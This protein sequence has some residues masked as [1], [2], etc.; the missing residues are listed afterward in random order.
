MLQSKLQNKP[1]KTQKPK[2]ANHVCIASS[3]LTTRVNINQIA[4]HALFGG[5]GSIKN[6]T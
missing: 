5:T 2:K 1:T 6:S 3:A 4:I